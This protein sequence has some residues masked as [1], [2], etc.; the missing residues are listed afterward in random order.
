MNNTI[1]FSKFFSEKA[2]AKIH[3]LGK[4]ALLGDHKHKQ[5]AEPHIK[6]HA[7][8]S[9]APKPT[10]PPKFS[11][12][13]RPRFSPEEIEAINN[14]GNLKLGDWNKIKLRSKKI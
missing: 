4:R 12:H 8:P 13:Y 7:T 11:F 2:K 9:I 1:K 14:G 3:F 5:H 10:Q 6:S